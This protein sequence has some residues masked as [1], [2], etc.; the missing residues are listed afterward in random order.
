[1]D[2]AI[3][4]GGGPA[5]MQAA[6]TLG[7]M[8]RTTVLIDSG[9]Y[10]NGTVEHAQNLLT[11]DGRSPAELRA[12]GRAELARYATVRMAEAEVREVGP[13]GEGFAVRTDAEELTARTVILATGLRDEL[14]PVPGL[15][16]A[17]GREVAHCP[18]CHGHEVAGR[19]VGILG[20]GDH[21]ARHRALLTPIAAEV[22]MW[23]PAEVA[24]VERVEDGLRVHVGDDAVEVGGLF[25]APV[26][27]QRAPFAEQLGLRMTP[28]GLVEVDAMGG[29]SLPGVYAAGDI[30]Q[31]ADGTGAMS[32]LAFSIASGQAA[33]AAAVFRLSGA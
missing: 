1:M 22:L 10:R 13:R 20:A 21:A 16:E 2:D 12:I 27:T 24:A 29:T 28:M 32:S 7:R 9:A 3:V 23:D 5:G 31:R 8:H 19:R 18:F 15:A 30:G 33:A 25:V 14:P 4:I 17:W 6:L 26:S 11:N